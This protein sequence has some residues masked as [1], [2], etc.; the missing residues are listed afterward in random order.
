MGPTRSIGQRGSLRE[1]LCPYTISFRLARAARQR[2]V[3][4][5]ACH[6]D[7]DCHLAELHVRSSMFDCLRDQLRVD[8]IVL[9]AVFR[10]H[11]FAL[12]D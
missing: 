1:R 5:A 3:F 11:G 4:S 10:V 6:L 2:P 9:I 7:V 8:A 12:D